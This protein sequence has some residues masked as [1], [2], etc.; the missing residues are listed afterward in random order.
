[1]LATTGAAMGMA[2]ELMTTPEPMM[3]MEGGM[4]KMKMLHTMSKCSD[5][6]AKYKATF[7][8]AKMLP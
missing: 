3:G 8:A 4:G 7:C 6:P 5:G 2:D 1:M